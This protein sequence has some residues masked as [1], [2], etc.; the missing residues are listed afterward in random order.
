ML[1]WILTKS[2]KGKLQVSKHCNSEIRG[3]IFHALKCVEVYMDP[4][5]VMWRI[6]KGHTL[7]LMRKNELD[8]GKEIL[9]VVCVSLS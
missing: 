2:F 8:V 4:H 9:H 7:Y 3:L 6:Y 5:L 1:C